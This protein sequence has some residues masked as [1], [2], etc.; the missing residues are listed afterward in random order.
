MTNAIAALAGQQNFL[1]AGL[2][3]GTSMDGVDAAIVRFDASARSPRAELLAFVTVPYPDELRAS[4]ADLTVGHDTT[5]EEIALLN[6]SVAVAFSAAFFEVCRGAGIDAKQVDFIGSHGQTVAHAPPIKGGAPVAGTLQLGPPGAIAALTE[7]T[8]VGDF[9]VGDIAM[10]GQGAPLAPAADY[11]LRRSEQCGRIILNIGGVANVTFLPRGCQRDEVV[12]FDSGPGNMVIDELYR[13]L[14]A[15]H[16]SFDSGGAAAASGTVS[17]PLLDE[18]IE[19]AYFNAVPPKSAGHREFGPRYAW[20]IQ[21]RAQ[22]LGLPRADTLAT[23]TSLTVD[24]IV[25]AIERFVAPLGEVSELYLTGGGVHNETIVSGLTRRLG[26]MT[27]KPIDVLGIPA[28]AKE[29]VDFALLA[30]EAVL[31]R[32]N[33]L[34]NVTGATKAQVLGTIAAGMSR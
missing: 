23:V 15:G 8:T 27:L 17:Q 26:G 6:M 7:V 25:Y 4:L 14:F 19:N 24:T 30:R 32:P 1:V 20:Q 22:E 3:S 12:A 9:R 2:M 5:A 29:A 28:D 33:V 34:P 11:L 13:V 10:G 21:S 16:G 31:G 18:L